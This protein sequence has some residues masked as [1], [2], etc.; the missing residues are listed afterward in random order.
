ME[1]EPREA[2]GEYNFASCW[3]AIIILSAFLIRLLAA[4]CW[5]VYFAHGGFVYGDSDGYWTLAQNIASGKPYEYYGRQIFRMPGYPLFLAALQAIFGTN[6]PILYGRIA[7]AVLGAF[8][9]WEIWAI[10]RLLYGEKSG[11][12]AAAIAAIYPDQPHDFIGNALF[13]FSAGADILLGS[14]FYFFPLARR[15]LDGTVWRFGDFS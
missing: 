1:N 14:R 4:V 7:G 2:E 12:I 9:V 13:R 15:S 5:D 8:C 3:L 6:V 11:L 10:A